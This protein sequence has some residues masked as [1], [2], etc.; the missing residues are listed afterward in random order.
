MQGTTTSQV[1][2][3]DGPEQAA[4]VPLDNE[5]LVRAWGSLI[6]RRV[7]QMNRV[8]KHADDIT[9]HVFTELFRVRV[10]DKF[11]ASPRFDKKTVLG[12]RC[13]LCT[14]VHNIFC[15]WCR[16]WYRRHR[17]FSEQRWQELPESIDGDGASIETFDGRRSGWPR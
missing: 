4:R 6:R 17:A 16:T 3:R 7:R 1:P 5:E 11:L 2:P 13:Y 15:N 12:F 10:I 14:A 8:P 9:Q